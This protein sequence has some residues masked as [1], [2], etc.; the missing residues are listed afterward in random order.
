MMSFDELKIIADKIKPFAKQVYLHLYGEPLLNK[1]IFLMT[2][3]VSKF[4]RVNISTNGQLINTE[5]A[6]KLIIS[7]VTD[8][9]VSIDGVTQD[10]YEMYRVGGDIKKA[11]SALEI[12]VSANQLYGNHVNILPQFIVFRHNEHQI[13]QFK[14]ICRSLGL[15]PQFKAPFIA[16]NSFFQRSSDHQYWRKYFTNFGRYCSALS[17]DCDTIRSAMT[18]LLD[19]S[20]VPCCYDYQGMHSFGN[21]FQQD[22]L[23]IWKSPQ[24]Y[25]FRYDAY[26]GKIPKFCIDNCLMYYYDGESVKCE[27]AV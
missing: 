1:D 8:V 4:S 6:E 27:E 3:Y 14:K 23:D 22:V 13:D 20:V 5:I 18:I 16:N 21:I 15:K 12:L 11:L 26:W 25:K 7:G 24:Y 17:K 19:G 10:V 2:Q 9:I